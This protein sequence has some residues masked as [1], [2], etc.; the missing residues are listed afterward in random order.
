MV[1]FLVEVTAD[2]EGSSGLV[3]P[4]SGSSG[5]VAPDSSSSG[6][7]APATPA[8]PAVSTWGDVSWTT[9]SGVKKSDKHHELNELCLF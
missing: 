4:D 1:I 8:V 6:L 5:L 3:A 9:A 7:V 2:T